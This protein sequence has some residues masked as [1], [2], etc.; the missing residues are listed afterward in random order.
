MS[1][2]NI[3]DLNPDHFLIERPGLGSFKVSATDI[4]D[5]LG[6]GPGVIETPVKIMTPA[7]QSGI[8]DEATAPNIASLELQ[9]VNGIDESIKFSGSNCLLVKQIWTVEQSSDNVTFTPTTGSP[10]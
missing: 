9:T 6:G 2:I 1:T 7:D 10:I 3:D 4:N 5:Q 8:A